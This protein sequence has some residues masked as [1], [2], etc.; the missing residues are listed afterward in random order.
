MTKR[1]IVKPIIVKNFLF[2]KFFP[3]FSQQTAFLL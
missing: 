2:N 1:S 3:Q